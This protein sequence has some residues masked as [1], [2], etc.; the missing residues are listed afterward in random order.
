MNVERTIN[1]CGKEV[2]MCYCAATETGYETISGK[3]SI[4]F[5]PK[6]IKD[7]NGKVQTVEPNCN[8]ADCITLA[9][10]G[11]IASYD[12]RNQEAPIT[13][14]D[15]LYHA[16]PQEVQ[17]LITS[18]LEMRNEWYQVPAMIKKEDGSQDQDS[19]AAGD[20]DNQKN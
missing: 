13:S 8:M 7:A 9:V 16:A 15:I 18:I 5:V 10:A 3:S 6:V 14:Q 19:E 4:I 1:I 11:I 20:S 17:N 12:F 2:F